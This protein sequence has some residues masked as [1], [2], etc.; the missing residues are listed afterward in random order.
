M[1]VYLHLL[2]Y[3]IRVNVQ[4]ICDESPHFQF[5]LRLKSANLLDINSAGL[6]MISS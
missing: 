4:E 1:V 3:I 2:V 6:L 5:A